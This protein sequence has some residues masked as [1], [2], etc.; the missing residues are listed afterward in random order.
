MKAARWHAANDVRVEEV[1]EPVPSDDEA[2]IAVS[3]CGLC[4]SD[5]E[6]FTS[7]PV[8]LGEVPVTLGHEVVGRVVHAAANGQGPATGTRV[9]VD[10]VD[11]CGHCWWCLRHEEGLCPDLRVRGQHIDGGLAELMTA[12]A[13]HLVTIPAGLADD[14]AALAE[15]LAV[16]VRAVGKC[17]SLLGRAVLVLGGGSI[18]QLVAR[19]ARHGGASTVV[20]VDPLPTRR[21][22]ARSAGVDAALHPDEVGDPIGLVGSRGFDVVVECAGRPGVTPVAFEQVRRG[23]TVVL[24]GVPTGPESLNLLGVVLKE[25][26]VRGSAAHRWDDD[27]RTAVELIASGA[28]AVDDLITTRIALDDVVVAGLVPM[29]DHPA[30][31]IKILVRCAPG[32]D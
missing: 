4:G 5:L 24:T 9:V 29:R 16:A 28:V 32:S 23:G 11:G 25:L 22:V 13:A 18:G 3:W 1:P 15:P 2:V 17:G 27:V 20:L 19:T 12:R 7:G 10:V 8:V 31:D 26:T 30:D 14:L 21:E 6:E